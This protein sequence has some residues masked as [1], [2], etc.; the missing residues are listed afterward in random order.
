MRRLRA[1]GAEG[2]LELPSF[3]FAADRDPLDRHTL[4]AIA[5]GVSTRKYGRSLE[6]LADAEQRSTSKSAVSRRFVALSRQ[7]MTRWLTQPLHDLDLPVLVIDGIVFRDH[8]ILIVLG[9]DSDGRKHVLGLR[10]GTTE[11]SRV[12]T[13]LLHDL[14][15]R[16]LDPQRTRVFVID[17]SKACRR[18]TPRRSRAL[19][20]S[21]EKASTRLRSRSTIA[22]RPSRIWSP[23][24]FA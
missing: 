14:L 22:K 5:C 3:V 21:A 16:G 9:V 18:M 2:E 6:P 10:E 11:N 19:S 13:A 4:E 20:K 15:E 7:Q 24:R 12:A 17:G 23:S 8:T 1:R